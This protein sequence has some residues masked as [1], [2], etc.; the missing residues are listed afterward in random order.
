MNRREFLAAAALAPA[1]A[2]AYSRLIR[3]GK[4]GRLEYLPDEQGNVIPDFSCAGY[5]GGGVE[6]PDVPVRAT[7]RPEPGD[8][9]AR[10]QAAIDR[11]AAAG[12]AVLLPRGRYEIAGTLR[13]A[14]GGIVL[15]GEDDTVLAATGTANA[16]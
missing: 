10:I 13:I 15:R 1:E 7:V 2:P 16:R 5:A 12:G 4:N 3:P 9:T 8:A 6:L 11:V 14:A